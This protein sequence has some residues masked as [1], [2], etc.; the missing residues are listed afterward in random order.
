M[1]IDVAEENKSSRFKIIS[2]FNL[3][4]MCQ[5]DAMTLVLYSPIPYFQASNQSVNVGF[6]KTV[7]FI[8]TNFSVTHLRI[9]IRR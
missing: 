5:R 1:S 6:I 7:L 3:E 9:F 4:G 8:G 2:P